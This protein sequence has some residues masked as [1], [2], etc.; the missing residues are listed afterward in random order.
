[1]DFVA[2]R[3]VL[4]RRVYLE[5][6]EAATDVLIQQVLT[7]PVLGTEPEYVRRTLVGRTG[8][9]IGLEI[10]LAI[11]VADVAAGRQLRDWIARHVQQS[12]PDAITARDRQAANYLRVLR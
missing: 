7:D 11:A 2:P 12:D 9:S 6:I 5:E 10:G 1:M 8:Y 4:I 3:D